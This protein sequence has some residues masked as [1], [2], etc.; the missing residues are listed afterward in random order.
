MFGRDTLDTITECSTTRPATHVE[1]VVLVDFSPAVNLM[2]TEMVGNRG[3]ADYCMDFDY[4]GAKDS[5]NTLLTISQPFVHDMC[6][7]NEQNRVMGNFRSRSSDASYFGKR[8]RSH[9][10]RPQ[11]AIPGGC[12]GPV[13]C[14]TGTAFKKA[15]VITMHDSQHYLHAVTAKQFD[16]G[17]TEFK[18]PDKRDAMIAPHEIPETG[19]ED[20]SLNNSWG[21]HYAHNLKKFDSVV[22]AHKQNFMNGIAN[23]GGAPA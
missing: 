2:P 9:I 14:K 16:Y 10:R 7:G 5:K 8:I 3:Y 4:K 1:N 19:P 12:N 11:D 22:N 21:L 20:E 23:Q 15:G 6:T 17:G 13:F 18:Q